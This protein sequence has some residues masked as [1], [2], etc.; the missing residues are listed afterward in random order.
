MTDDQSEEGIPED[1]INSI[2]ISNF[3]SNKLSQIDKKQRQEEL[4]KLK[5]QGIDQEPGSPLRHDAI[6]LPNQVTTQMK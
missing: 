5:A 4:E 2:T 6:R 1:R 3:K